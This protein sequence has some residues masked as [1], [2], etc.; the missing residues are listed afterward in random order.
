[1]SD[2]QIVANGHNTLPC[3]GKGSTL[4]RGDAERL[5]QLL[6]LEGI[7]GERFE[8]NT[9]GFTQAYI[10]TGPHARQLLQGGRTVQMGVSKDGGKGAAKVPRAP[11]RRGAAAAAVVQPDDIEYDYDNEEYNPFEEDEIVVEDEDRPDTVMSRGAPAADKAGT[12]SG[13]KTLPAQGASRSKQALNG[14]GSAHAARND[15]PYDNVFAELIRMREQVRTAF[16]THL[17]LAY[18]AVIT[19]G[20][21]RIW[22]RAH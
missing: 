9:L 6:C 17:I 16:I 14:T 7:L 12:S 20:G 11:A 18:I 3:A 5:F 8:R 1:M 4:D 21:K 13:S 15:L 10:T 19:L 22:M 2:L